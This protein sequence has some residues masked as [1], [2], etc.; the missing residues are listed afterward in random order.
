MLEI[1]KGINKLIF[2]FI[3]AAVFSKTAKLETPYR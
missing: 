2:L 1:N 3:L